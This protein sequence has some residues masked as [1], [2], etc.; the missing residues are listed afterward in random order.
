MPQQ[1]KVERE[2]WAVMMN[3]PGKEALSLYGQATRILVARNLI[4]APR[5]RKSKAKPDA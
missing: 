1:T 5:V 4:K 2:L 3:S